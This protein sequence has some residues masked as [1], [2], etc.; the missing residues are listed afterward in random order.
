M[1]NCLFCDIVTGT[2]P[3]HIVYQD[4][5]CTAFLDIFP[6]RPGH[7]LVIP[8]THAADAFSLTTEQLAH[9][10]TLGQRI[11]EALKSDKT[12]V[13]CDGV[14]LVMNNGKAAA[15]T[16]FHSHL[17]VIPRYRGDK[18]AV[19]FTLLRKLLGPLNIRSSDKKLAVIAEQI[20]H[21]LL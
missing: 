3:A 11:G 7:V 1:K 16:V 10:T 21:S 13:R 8:N 17:H 18:L 20:R 9:I 14:H 15:Q 6:M 4:D 19:T 12:D 5:V 2:L